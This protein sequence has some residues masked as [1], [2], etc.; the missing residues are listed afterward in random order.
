[1]LKGVPSFKSVPAGNILRTCQWQNK[2][3]SS[4]SQQEQNIVYNNYFFI[5]KAKRLSDRDVTIHSTHNQGRKFRLTVGG[6]G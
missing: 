5:L 2:V 1:M 6:G 3:F 4:R